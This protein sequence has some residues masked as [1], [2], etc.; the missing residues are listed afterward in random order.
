MQISL[1]AIRP[2]KFRLI[3][4]AKTEQEIRGGLRQYLNE[5]KTILQADYG[6]VAPSPNYTR[7]GKTGAGW[8]VSVP[9][10][11]YG[12]L[13]NVTPYAVFVQ[14]PFGGGRGIGSRQTRLNRSKG[15]QSITDVARSTSKRYAQIMNRS[16]QPRILD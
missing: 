13:T 16:I 15:W 5:V 14:G 4:P 8:Q 9:S 12:E 1:R 7:T 6:K 10:H 11:N 3:D 2:T